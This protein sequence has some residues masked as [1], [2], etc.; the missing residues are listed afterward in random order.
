MRCN[1]F[2]LS[3]HGGSLLGKGRLHRGANSIGLRVDILCEQ[4]RK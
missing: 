1:R 2:E 3:T 4:Q